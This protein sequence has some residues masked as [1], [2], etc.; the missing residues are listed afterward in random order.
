[1]TGRGPPRKKRKMNNKTE[2]YCICRKPDDYKG[3]V[4]CGVCMEWL[5]FACIGIKSAPQMKVYLGDFEC[6][7]CAQNEK[8]NLVKNAENVNELGFILRCIPLQNVKKFIMKQIDDN[9]IDASLPFLSEPKSLIQTLPNDLLQSILSFDD[10][11]VKTAKVCRRWDRISHKMDCMELQQKY[12]SIKKQI[13]C[14]EKEKALINEINAIER[15][16]RSI[17]NR[18]D[19]RYDLDRMQ[20]QKRFDEKV[21]ALR[22]LSKYRGNGCGKRGYD[23]CFVECTVC[24]KQLCKQCMLKCE[25]CGT[26][27]GS[28]EFYCCD[29]C[30][31]RGEC[32]GCFRFLCKY[33]LF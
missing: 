10:N 6:P 13:K 28:D 17:L 30:D 16:K 27:W 14:D 31:E 33:I 23:Q 4:Q 29:D 1:M 12:E 20:T 15:Q 5:H 26:D 2:T 8:R 11:R 19:R 3:M 18:I 7:I 32:D 24:S 9:A 25:H 22:K 21:A